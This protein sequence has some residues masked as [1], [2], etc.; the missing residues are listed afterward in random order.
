MTALPEDQRCG[1]RCCELRDN[2]TRLVG[3]YSCSLV[4]EHP[5]PHVAY[6]CHEPDKEVLGVWE[7]VEM[8]MPAL[9]QLDRDLSDA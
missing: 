1:N 2:P 7:S 8:V 5:G 4:P 3:L 6:Y 9:L